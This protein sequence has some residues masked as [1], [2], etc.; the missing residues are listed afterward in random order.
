MQVFALA[1]AALEEHAVWAE[2]AGLGLMEQLILWA[3]F[4]GAWLLVAGP[5]QQARVAYT[6][7]QAAREVRVAETR[8][9][10]K[11]AGEPQ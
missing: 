1:A 9:E 4:L 5:L 2:G 7:L 3:G 11:G 8:T 6:A 10:L